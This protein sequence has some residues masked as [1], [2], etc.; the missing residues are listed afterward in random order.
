MKELFEKYKGQKVV[1]ECYEEGVICGYSDQNKLLIM[2]V[3]EGQG[4]IS[5]KTATIVTHKK[6]PKGYLYVDQ[7]DFNR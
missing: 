4:W 7:E 6:N 2:A 3:T 5:S 1:A